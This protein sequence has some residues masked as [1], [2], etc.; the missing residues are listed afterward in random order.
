MIDNEYAVNNNTSLSVE[1][2][3]STSQPQIEVKEETD[4]EGIP[5]EFKN[6]KSVHPYYND[7]IH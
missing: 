2:K 4:K 3:S 5:E 6:F 1:A 7:E